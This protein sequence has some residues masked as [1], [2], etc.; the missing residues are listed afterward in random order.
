[1]AKVYT[2]KVA[3]RLLMKRLAMHHQARVV[4][5]RMKEAGWWSLT[6]EGQYGPGVKDT[7]FHLGDGPLDE[8]IYFI[9]KIDE[10]YRRTWNRS[11]TVPELQAILQVPVW[12]DD[13]GQELFGSWPMNQWVDVA[14]LHMDVPQS[15]VLSLPEGSLRE[16]KRLWRECL[17]S[18]IG[19]GTVFTKDTV[20][21]EP[22]KELLREFLDHIKASFMSAQREAVEMVDAVDPDRLKLASMYQADKIPGG[23]G[24]K[25][26]PSD[27]DPKQLAK[28]VKVEMEHTD[29]KALAREIA[30]DHL[31]ESGNA[32]YYDRLETIEKHAGH[33]EVQKVG[34]LR[35]YWDA[36]GPRER[37]YGVSHTESD[38][39]GDLGQI[40]F[41]KMD[42]SW[43]VNAYPD[44]PRSDRRKVRVTTF[45]AKDDREGVKRAL[46]ALQGYWGQAG[47]L[48]SVKK[49]EM[50]H[51][52][53]IALMKWLSQ[54][55]KRLGVAEHVYVVGGA[56]RNFVLE[57][58]IKDVD[59]VID[60][61]AL[62]GRKDSGWLA[63]QLVRDIPA[64][65]KIVTDQYGV[66]KIFVT[67]PWDLDGYEMMDPEQAA[68]EIVN[69]RKE[70]YGEGYKPIS[71]EPTTLEEDVGRR[72]FTFNTLMWRLNDLA[73]GPDK[74]EIIDLTGCGKADL[75]AR[76]MQCPRDPDETFSDDA[77]RLLRVI[78]FVFKYGFK[79]PPDLAASIK[80]N[81]PKLRS[82][83]PPN[84]TGNLLINV[85]L[86]EPTYKKA[87]EAMD[88]LG[89]LDVIREMLVNPKTTDEKALQSFFVGHIKDRGV[90]YMFDLMDVGLPAGQAVSF[91]SGDQQR[92]VREITFG[93][94]R[95]EAWD[96]VDALKTPGVAFKDNKFQPSLVAKYSIP[97]QQM[98][99]FMSL[100]AGATRELLLADPSLIK[101][102]S[103]LKRD[104]AQ[105]VEGTMKR[106]RLA[107]STGPVTGDRKS[108]GIFIPLPKELADQF[109]ALGTDDKSP[110]HVTLFYG[111]DVPA[112][113][114]EEYLGILLDVLSRVGVV[115]ARLGDLDYFTQV[116]KDRRVAFVRVW[117]SKD[118]GSVRDALK[119]ALGQAGFDVQ[120]MFPLAFSPHITLEYMPDLTAEYAGP[121]PSGT[122]EFNSV[123]V[124]G[125]PH[126][127]DILLTG[128]WAEPS[129]R[130]VACQ[131]LGDGSGL[132]PV[133][134]P[135]FN[136]RECAKQLLLLEDH[137][138]HPRK[139]CPDCVKKHTLMAE[140]L[141]EEAVTL[142]TQQ[143]YG[144]LLTGLADQVRAIG[145]AI[146][147]L[148]LEEVGQMIRET[149]KTLV[150]G[151]GDSAL[152][153]LE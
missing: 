46:L 117:F 100:V 87:L 130:R 75:D 17:N 66:A 65:T 4:V 137:L 99:R 33:K 40:V 25:A 67:S 109:P 20:L 76:V 15:V 95:D 23:V 63:K 149:R 93:M 82:K 74:A 98:G 45:T 3:G 71:V 2:S 143:Q 61:L 83:V 89:L 34:V 73:G 55:A 107:K 7:G 72:E 22:E 86:S 114:E 142:D 106:T 54:K 31:S 28:G 145:E 11:V 43:V 21:P 81:A 80:R 41:N 112:D 90:G 104:V 52:A 36:N 128:G 135:L 119:N 121:V 120:D 153:G 30:L 136:V 123:P 102:T 49:A 38:S 113:R 129:A 51:A 13:D 94:D 146:K 134:N 115:K 1:M 152:G 19:V 5:T 10:M 78:K 140:A 84:Q 39:P 47:K 24:D 124:W 58:P 44:W 96:F 103:Q 26:K 27:V 35:A 118:M 42:S 37:V 12:A 68:I 79:V 150:N 32:D 148:P 69:A 77:S 133:M 16:A 131:F 50:T 127:R 8:R 151:C 141:A 85:I 57:K 138:F 48:A 14:A 101:S 122:W 144:A 125:L 56:V 60:S 6:E 92:R 111:G 110:T 70:T 29:D 116:D 108:V 88:D 126:E 9:E 105:A 147:R 132:Y 18:R 91:L 59:M 53:S 62:G 97:K 139:R 64:M